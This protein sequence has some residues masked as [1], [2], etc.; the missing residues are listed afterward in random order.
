[1][2]FAAPLPGDTEEALGALYD[3]ERDKML[4]NGNTETAANKSFCFPD[5]NLLMIF[6]SETQMLEDDAVNPAL[7]ESHLP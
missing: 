1:L 5:G 6:D 3:K 2:P 7:T 4:E